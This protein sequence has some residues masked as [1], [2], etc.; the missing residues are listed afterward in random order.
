MAA[1]KKTSFKRL[2]R[3]VSNFIAL[4]LSHSVRQILAIFSGVEFRDCIK[5]QKKKKKAVASCSR[6]SQNEKLG[7]FTS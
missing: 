5:V 7:I 1:A 3:A 6:P 2:G 4:I